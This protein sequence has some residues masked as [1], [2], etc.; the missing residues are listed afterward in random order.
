[1]IK[2]GEKIGKYTRGRIRSHKLDKYYGKGK[3]AL[4]AYCDSDKR[5]A[6]CINANLSMDSTVRYAKH[7]RRPGKQNMVMKNIL[8]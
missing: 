5:K 1:M 7:A 6:C 2:R 8:G 4:Y 3:H